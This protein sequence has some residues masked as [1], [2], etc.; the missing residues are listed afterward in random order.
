MIAIQR[1][2]QSI[3][4]AV[5]F[6]GCSAVRLGYDQA[7]HLGYWWVDHYLDLSSDKSRQFKADLQA[8]HAWH[9]QSQLPEYAR[10]ASELSTRMGGEP[11]SAEVCDN[12][13]VLREKFELLSRQSVPVWARLAQQLGPEEIN[14]LRKKFTQE[15]KEWKAKWLDADVEKIHDL[16]YEDWLRRAELFYGRLNH[17]QKKFIQQ[18]IVHSSWD[19]RISWERRQQRQQKIIA[20]LEKIRHQHLSQF[21]V[22]AE[23]SLIIEQIVNPE[24]PKQANLQ[25]KVVE[26]ACINIAGLH[27]RTTAS[28]RR[29]ASE[30]FSDYAND[31]RYLTRSR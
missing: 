21:D 18:A 29:H 27:Q 15:D 30:K 3:L 10:L 4:I 7:D 16:R 28:Q 12:I 20:V 26:E 2:L 22:E 14:Y 9:R 17:D 25:R 6:T 8:L 11:S 24:D 19:P 5:L 1:I 31:F 23:L 13:Q